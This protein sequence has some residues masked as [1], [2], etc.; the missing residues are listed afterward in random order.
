M[1]AWLYRAAILAA[2]P[3]LTYMSISRDKTGIIIGVGTGVA[4]VV[5]EV[6]LESVS[7]LTTVFGLLGACASIILMRLLDVVVFNT[8]NERVYEL[9]AQFA[10]LRYFAIGA[11]GMVLSIRK[12][13][14]LDSLDRDILASSKK[15]GADMKV[16][17]TSA[18]IDGRVVE[19]CE[20]H[21]LSGSLVV[22]RFVINELHHMADSPDGLKRAR[23]RR[24]LDMLARLQ[25]NREVR[26]RILDR[27]VPEAA[28]VDGKLVRLAQE[29]GAKLLTTDFN[30]SKVATVEGVPCLNVNDLTMVL[31]PVVLPGETMGVFVMKEGKERDQGV[32]Y[33]DDGTMVVIEGGARHVG[34]RVEGTV[35][36]I[37]QTKAGRMVF[38]KFKG[39]R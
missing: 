16:L 10:T 38:I 39:D 21:F 31:K 24:G 4:L 37:T 19:I 32:G 26:L 25:E 36:S 11:L 1:S 5:V 20:V 17:D 22:P 28:E 35:T 9:W 7:L 29:L 34:K 23:G 30:L 15:R 13:P 12:F 6:V 3:L 27:D 2:C 33:L 8:G 18:I 14:E